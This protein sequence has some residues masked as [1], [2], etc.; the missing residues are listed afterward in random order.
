M[1]PLSSNQSNLEVST[2]LFYYNTFFP[3]NLPASLFNLLSPVLLSRQDKKHSK[4]KDKLKKRLNQTPQR[5]FVGDTS[6]GWFTKC[7]CLSVDCWTVISVFI[8]VT[9]LPKV[10]VGCWAEHQ[11]KWP[12]IKG[13]DGE[14][15]P[16]RWFTAETG[17]DIWAKEPSKH[18]K[19]FQKSSSVR[20]RHP[21]G[22]SFAKVWQRRTKKLHSVQSWPMGRRR[23][24]E[25][26]L[27]R[28][29]PGLRDGHWRVQ[30]DS[31]VCHTVQLQTHLHE[32]F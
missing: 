16:I 20:R 28:G 29:D 21:R 5:V 23:T 2:K 17:G 26:M 13:R 31:E 9:H 1:S 11:G 15:K 7:G 6:H 10:G 27:T 4:G 24:T 30:V 25:K 3:D 8:L 18:S 12:C 32:T 22:G 14:W 19:H